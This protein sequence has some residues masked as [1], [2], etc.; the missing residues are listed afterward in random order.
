MAFREA[1]PYDDIDE[2]VRRISA[3]ED[4]IE[5]VSARVEKRAAEFKG[6]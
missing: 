6:R 1:T 5:G 3:S 2:E 4:A